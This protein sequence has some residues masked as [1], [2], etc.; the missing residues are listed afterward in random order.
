MTNFIENHP[1]LVIAAHALAIFVGMLA[2]ASGL[3]GVA[4]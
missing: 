4:H 3:T 2:I 1:R